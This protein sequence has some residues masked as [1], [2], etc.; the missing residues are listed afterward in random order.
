MLIVF[1]LYTCI[2][3]EFVRRASNEVPRLRVQRCGLG[4]IVRRKELN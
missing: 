4:P 1:F 2:M 3:N